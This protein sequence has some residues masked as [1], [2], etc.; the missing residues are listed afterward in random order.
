MFQPPIILANSSSFLL[1]FVG[2]LCTN[3]L[4][5]NLIKIFNL[6]FTWLQLNFPVQITSVPGVPSALWLEWEKGR[7]FIFLIFHGQTGI[8]YTNHYWFSSSRVPGIASAFLLFVF[9]NNLVDTTIWGHF[10][11]QGCHLPF[12][13]I[14]SPFWRHLKVGEHRVLPPST[15]VGKEIVCR[16]GSIVVEAFSGDAKRLKPSQGWF[17]MPSGKRCGRQF[18]SHNLNSASPNCKC[19]LML[20]QQRDPSCALYL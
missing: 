4:I 7:Q 10:S 18:E 15:R 19:N 17:S 11:R 9:I 5:S 1:C 14:S 16:G 12:E 2:F 8:R 20:H 13:L 6:V 3:F